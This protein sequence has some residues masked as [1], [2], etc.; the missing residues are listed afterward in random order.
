MKLKQLI[1]FF[2]INIFLSSA[3]A[4]FI[5]KDIGLRAKI[6]TE[7]NITLAYTQQMQKLKLLNNAFSESEFSILVDKISQ[8]VYINKKEEHICITRIIPIILSIKLLHMESIKSNL[9]R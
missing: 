3:Y 5:E 7:N 8:I 2:A 9:K 1:I 4:S 6:I